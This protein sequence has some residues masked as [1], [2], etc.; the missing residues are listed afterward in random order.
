[1]NKINIFAVL[2]ILLIGCGSGV[3]NEPIAVPKQECPVCEECK[4]CPV[5][6][7]CPAEGETIFAGFD[8]FTDRLQ[9]DN[10]KLNHFVNGEM[11]EECFLII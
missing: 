2:G 5:V 11:V 1:M 9:L 7:Q 8:E 4:E 6:P 3:S 10:I